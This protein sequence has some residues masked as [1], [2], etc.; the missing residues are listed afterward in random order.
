MAG[1]CAIK[2]KPKSANYRVAV[3]ADTDGTT[4]PGWHCFGIKGTVG[5]G[6]DRTSSLHIVVVADRRETSAVAVCRI[7]PQ[8]HQIHDEH[9]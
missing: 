2:P 6:V 8:R 4:W 1:N 7:S 9:G 5:R 3:N